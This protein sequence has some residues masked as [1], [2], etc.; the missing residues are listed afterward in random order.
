ME[1]GVDYYQARAKRAG[2]P[3]LTESHCAQKSLAERGGYPPPLTEKVRSVVF[4][5][6]PN[7]YN[8][9]HNILMFPL[10]W[11]KQLSLMCQVDVR[12]RRDGTTLHIFSF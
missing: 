6:F 3:P 8:D 4:V 10:R 12:W 11:V 5:G 2:P 7:I 9:L 1:N